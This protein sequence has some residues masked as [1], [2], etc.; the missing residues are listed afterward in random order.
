MGEI[1]SVS[2][3]SFEACHEHGKGFCPKCCCVSCVITMIVQAPAHPAGQENNYLHS[4]YTRGH[5]VITVRCYRVATNII[6]HSLGCHW[7]S[8]WHN[9]TK[10]LTLGRGMKSNYVMILLD[11]EEVFRMRHLDNLKIL[12]HRLRTESTEENNN[13]FQPSGKLLLMLAALRSKYKKNNS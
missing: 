11:K 12:Q 7:M 13:K 1:W 8:R 2:T 3:W 4:K 10:H 9:V 6:P 5:L